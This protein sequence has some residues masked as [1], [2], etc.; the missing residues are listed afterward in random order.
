MLVGNKCDL[1]DLRAVPM[2]AGREFAEKEG[3]LFLETSALDATNVEKAFLTVLEQIY[4][5]VSRRSL[6][7]D[8]APPSVL[9]S[10]LKGTKLDVPN[11]RNN[12]SYC[13][14]S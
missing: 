10:G 8:G 11:D 1:G 2:E 3:L 9:K 14:S 12:Y 6:S 5:V 13:C 4:R 7:I